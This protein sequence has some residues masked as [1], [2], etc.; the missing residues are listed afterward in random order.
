MP[1]DPEGEANTR[2]FESVLGRVLR[3][4]KDELAKRE[5]AYKRSRRAT[6][7]RHRRTA[8]T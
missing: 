4:S 7:R 1:S 3:M 2:R 6:K 8:K 5:A